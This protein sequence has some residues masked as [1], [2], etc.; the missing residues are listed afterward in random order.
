MN[1]H[2]H[3]CAHTHTPLFLLLDTMLPGF[4]WYTRNTWN[5]PV[6]LTNHYL[7]SEMN[8]WF[9][10]GDSNAL[11]LLVQILLTLLHLYLITTV[12]QL[13]PQKFM[14]NN[15]SWINILLPL[16]ITLYISTTDSRHCLFLTP[17]THQS[18]ILQSHKNLE[19]H[20]TQCP[21]HIAYSSDCTPTQKKYIIIQYI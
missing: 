7:P 19:Q 10:A 4:K 11:T 17:L 15:R 21:Q 2:T 3:L 6:S 8:E 16:F 18:I 13:Q 20:S 12:L 1:T 14:F 9:G 5:V